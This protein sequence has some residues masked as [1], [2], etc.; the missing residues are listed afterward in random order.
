M[1]ELID[2]KNIFTLLE[3][4][5]SIQKMFSQH[6]NGAYWIKAEMNKLGFYAQSGHCF[7]ELVE[8]RDGKIIAKIDSLIWKNDYLNIN[9]NFK[10]VLNDVLKDGIKILFLAKVEYNPEYGLKLRIIDIDPAFTLGD[11]ERERQETIKKLQAEGIFDRNKTLQFPLL[12]KRIAI[13]SDSDSRGYQDF[14]SVFEA[15]KKT[16]GYGF[17]HMLFTAS[18]QGEKA[19]ASIPMQLDRIQKVQHHFDIVA[20]IRGGGG[21]LTFAC[22]NNYE[23]SK[24][25]ATYP[26]PIVTGIGHVTNL[27]VVDMVANQ[28]AITPTKLAEY[29]IQ[30]FHNFS[31]PVKE[32]ED[33]IIDKSRRILRDE[34]IKFDSEIKLFRSVTINVL[35]KNNNKLREDSQTIIRQSQFVFKTEKEYLDAIREGIIKES[36]EYCKSEKENLVECV[37]NIKKE[38]TAL[39]KQHILSINQGSSQ[40]DNGSKN[41]IKIRKVDLF[42][43][44]KNIHNL[45]PKNVLKRGYSI[46]LSNGKPVTTFNKLKQGDKLNTILYE[47]NILSTVN[48]ISKPPDNEQTN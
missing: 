32:A 38:T 29:I 3:V 17:F 40:I 16:W 8:K 14:I 2:G 4:S 22:Y 47:G 48:S 25:I 24:K 12:P 44:E 33:I 43:T 34:K 5:Q 18:L 9:L 10:K 15:A 13:I 26:L 27:T 36:M 11:F 7:P 39:L 28:S 45:N 23:L 31:V 46:T 6:F 21:E 41:I 1:P 30:K 19:L 42:N 35:L 20:I 37:L